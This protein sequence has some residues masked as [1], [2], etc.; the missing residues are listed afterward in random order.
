MVQR[1]VDEKRTQSTNA[2]CGFDNFRWINASAEN[3]ANS[4]TR[5]ILRKI[6]PQV[7]RIECHD[8]SV[9]EPYTQ[10]KCALL[11]FNCQTCCA[12]R[13]T[14]IS[15]SGFPSFTLFSAS[16][17]YPSIAAALFDEVLHEDTPRLDH[18]QS[19]LWLREANARF[20]GLDLAETAT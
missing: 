15:L 1:L 12:R 17:S 9:L 14:S 7:L 5:C 3:S 10:S 18:N 2:K 4:D 13:K 20:V 11:E 6:L 16:S 19:L 8:F